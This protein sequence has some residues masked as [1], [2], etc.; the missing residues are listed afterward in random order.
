MLT[1]MN[2]CDSTSAINTRRKLMEL[3]RMQLPQLP[4]SDVWQI[5]KMYRKHWGRISQKH[6]YSHMDDFV[7]EG[8]DLT[9]DAV[10]SIMAHELADEC[11]AED[12]SSVSN[13]NLAKYIMG[14]VYHQGVPVT[15]PNGK[16]ALFEKPRRRR[17]RVRRNVRLAASRGSGR[18]RAAAPRPGRCRLQRPSRA[19]VT[20]TAR[21]T[22]RRCPPSRP[23]RRG[24]R[25]CSA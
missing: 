20:A 17:G 12:Q 15:I 13:H 24:R 25:S 19:V 16:W 6:Q 22:C 18:G 1:H 14:F 11:Y 5:I 3:N 10:H 2:A 23:H 7:D 21:G 4:N 8:N 9:D